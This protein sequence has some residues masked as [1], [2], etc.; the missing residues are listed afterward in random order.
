[1]SAYEEL[2]SE[3]V[4]KLEIEVYSLKAD[5]EVLKGRLVSRDR[6]V[7]ILKG[8]H[9]RTEYSCELEPDEWTEIQDCHRD[10]QRFF[11]RVWIGPEHPFEHEE[12]EIPPHWMKACDV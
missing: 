10:H 5:L 3:Q 11:R 4:S 9:W 7:A 8:G 6:L 1:M 12:I 2:L